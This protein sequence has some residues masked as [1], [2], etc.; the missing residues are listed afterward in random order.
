MK[1]FYKKRAHWY[2]ARS[3]LRKDRDNKFGVRSPLL[4]DNLNRIRRLTCIC[5]YL[6]LIAAYH[7]THF[8]SRSLSN[9]KIH[10]C[11]LQTSRNLNVVFVYFFI[12]KNQ[13]LKKEP[14]I[15]TPVVNNVG[16][17]LV[18]NLSYFHANVTAVMKHFQV[19]ILFPHILCSFFSKIEIIFPVL[20]SQFFNN[21]VWFYW[22]TE[23]FPCAFVTIWWEFWL[24]YR[25][26][27]WFTPIKDLMCTYNL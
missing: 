21:F 12:L 22:H 27:K 11:C 15:W 5:H 2:T 18:Y 13:E 4:T 8:Y 9:P 6:R 14:E 16:L 19:Y 26:N 10:K 23:T 3:I 1:K 25:E 17:I 24:R 7:A 20:V